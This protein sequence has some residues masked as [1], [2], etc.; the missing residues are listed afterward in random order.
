MESK[1]HQLS[2]ST[3]IFCQKTPPTSHKISIATNCSCWTGWYSEFCSVL[4]GRRIVT[5]IKYISTACV[6]QLRQMETKQSI[7]QKKKVCSWQPKLKKKEKKI[8]TFNLLFY[9]QTGPKPGAAIRHGCK[10]SKTYSQYC[11][12][13]I[14]ERQSSKL[15]QCRQCWKKSG[16]P[17][18]LGCWL[19]VWFFGRNAGGLEMSKWSN[20]IQRMGNQ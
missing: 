9:K 12:F 4:S 7:S 14:A 18:Y 2:G 6:C 11:D 15:F 13:I 19:V 3:Y 5:K 8:T 20:L 16:Y 17:L 1:L 10:L